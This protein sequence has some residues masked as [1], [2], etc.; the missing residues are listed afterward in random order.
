MPYLRCLQAL[1][2]FQTVEKGVVK[3]K[4]TFDK[5]SRL[6][7]EAEI[8]VFLGLAGVVCQYNVKK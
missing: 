4:I 6:F 7:F 8:T 2:G 1:K 3:C 5:I